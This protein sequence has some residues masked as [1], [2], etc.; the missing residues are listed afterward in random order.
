MSGNPIEMH[1]LTLSRVDQ[2]L[3]TG[4]AAGTPKATTQEETA[5]DFV[6][7]FKNFEKLFGIRK[8]KIYMTGES[9]AGRYVPYIS[10]VMLDRNDTEYY[11]LSGT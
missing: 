7:F 2:P 4:Y 8:Y 5:E 6:K 10:A 11:D 1:S 3:G 9:Y